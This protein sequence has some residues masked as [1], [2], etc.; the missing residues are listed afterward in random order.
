MLTESKVFPP[1]TIVIQAFVLM[2]LIGQPSVVATL[3]APVAAPE[4]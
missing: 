3:T 2:A 1:E 4:P